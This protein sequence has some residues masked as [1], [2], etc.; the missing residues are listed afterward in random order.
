ML[1]V[2]KF[3]RHSQLERW[4]DRCSPHDSE[5]VFIPPAD[6]VF[7]PRAALTIYCLP[8]WRIPR[9][10]LKVDE[11]LFASNPELTRVDDKT[12][13]Y[14]AYRLPTLMA[15]SPQHFVMNVDNARKRMRAFKQR[16]ASLEDPP[17]AFVLMRGR[18]SFPDNWGPQKVR[19]YRSQNCWDA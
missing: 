10:V 11:M 12:I 2:P 3:G 7:S 14:G 16:E 18:Y 8:S 1:I 13:V 19:E 6:L 17:G 5:N 15:E 4:L 9:T